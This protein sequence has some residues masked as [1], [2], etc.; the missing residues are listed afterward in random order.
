MKR[1]ALALIAVTV[2]VAFTGAQSEPI[3]YAAIG[4][5]RNEG[6]TRSQVMD[7]ISWLSD[8][9]G[10]RL[11]GSPALQQAAE[12]A[13]KRFGEWGLS[14]V[15]QERWKFGKGWSLVKFHATMIEPQVQPI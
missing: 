15:H 9:Y 11:T 6:M 7:H 2:A 14:N 5:I 3:D 4:R 12:W 1:F 13:M 8:V 10:P